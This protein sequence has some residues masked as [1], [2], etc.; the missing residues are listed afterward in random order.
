MSCGTTVLT[1]TNGSNGLR[2]CTRVNL[3]EQFTNVSVKISRRPAE[4][5]RNPQSLEA[6][7]E[8]NFDAGK[9]GS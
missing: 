6:S 1:I 9:P 4:N 8:D 3:E 7:S 5:S 2:I